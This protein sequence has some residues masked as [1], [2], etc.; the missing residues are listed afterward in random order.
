MTEKF[1]RGEVVLVDNQDNEVGVMDKMEAHEKG[2][3][4]RAFS[5][6]IFNSKGEMLI[7]QRA[8]EKYHSGGLWTNATCSHPGPGES[9]EASAIRRL[10]E[11]MGFE[12]PIEFRFSFIYHAN[13]DHG[14]QEH[15][16]D[17]VFVGTFDG[18]PEINLEEVMEYNYISVPELLADVKAHPEHYTEWFKI[19][20]DTMQSRGELG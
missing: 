15:E 9:V 17:H 18:T 6:V 20:L 10:Q 8:K 14:L 5:V 1:L 13:L 2:V 12:C 4:H 11:E 16:L 7:H 19:V 3:L